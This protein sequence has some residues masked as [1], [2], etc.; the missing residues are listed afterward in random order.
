MDMPEKTT[1]DFEGP[2][3]VSRVD[4]VLGMA[5]AGDDG[6]EVQFVD[7]GI[8]APHAQ[9]DA[10]SGSSTQVPMKENKGNKGEEEAK[11]RKREK[12]S[13]SG[14]SGGSRESRESTVGGSVEAGSRP[15]RP[16]S[17][18]KRRDD[19]G[20]VSAG[21]GAGASRGAYESRTAEDNYPSARGL[22]RK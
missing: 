12:P 14:A 6:E 21:A 4:Q 7:A 8:S 2:G 9:P 20:P 22:G 13:A 5:I 16:V 1:Q 19:S 17:A 10:A 11:P 18:V 3:M 15:V